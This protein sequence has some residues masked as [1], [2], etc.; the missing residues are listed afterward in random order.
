MIRVGIAGWSYDDWNGIVYP[1]RTPARFDRLAYMAE[2]FDAIE[3]NS[4]FYRIPDP[5]IAQSW[6]RRVQAHPRFR[7]TAK[8]YQGFTHKPHELQGGE[9]AAFKLAMEPLFDAGLLA[10]VLMQF[11]YSFR[12]S[13]ESR[14]ALER[15]CEAFREFPLVVEI[16]HAQ[17]KSDEFVEFLRARNV[18]FC[19]I[20]QPRV[21]RSIDPTEIATSRIGYVRLHGRNAAN[22]FN[23]KKSEPSDRYD[24]LY[25]EEELL[26]WGGRIERLAEKTADVFIIANN[27]YRGK[28]PLAALT[29]L[30]LMRGEKIAAPP[31]LV[32]AYPQL[33][34]HA[35][36]KGTAQGR[37]F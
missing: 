32:T 5:R 14:D 19:N 4:T 31:E 25:A 28:G 36:M 6:V 3:I 12:P 17:W 35:L 37:L 33:A 7:F 2:F 34:P 26:P 24:Y 21:A 9:E 11:P 8:L 29:L 1:S 13:P 23:K 16:R 10:A 20:D 22:W 15:L 30:A 18:G 27:H